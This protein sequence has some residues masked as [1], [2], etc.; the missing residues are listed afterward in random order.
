TGSRAQAVEVVTIAHG[1]AKGRAL[2][3]GT[4]RGRAAMHRIQSAMI[5]GLLLAVGAATIAHSTSGAT[6]N[7]RQ[8]MQIRHQAQ[9]AQRPAPAQEHHAAAK[10]QPLDLQTVERIIANWPQE[11]QKA[12]PATI[13]KYGPPQGATASLIEWHRNGRWKRTI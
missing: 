9:P 4:E 11:S 10:L 1:S 3:Q 6:H 8:L 2:S 12:A 7:N 13:E 5:A